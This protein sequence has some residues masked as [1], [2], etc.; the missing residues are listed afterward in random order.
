MKI[1]KQHT[2]FMGLLEALAILFASFSGANAGTLYR[3]HDPEGRLIVTDDAA[4]IAKETPRHLEEIPIRTLS[5]SKKVSQPQGLGFESLEPPVLSSESLPPNEAELPVK[6]RQ[7]RLLIPVELSHGTTGPIQSDFL[8]DTGATIT[9][10]AHQTASYL[11]ILENEGQKTRIYVGG[12]GTIQA[13]RYV[14]D[15]LRIGPYEWKHVLVHVLNEGLSEGQ[16]D[17]QQG[18]LGMNIL[19]DISYRLDVSRGWLSLHKK[20]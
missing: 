1:S 7:G 19:Q 15:A 6:V 9:V 10:L 18:I 8:L 5:P 12:G 20:E 4:R 11:G 13:K 16:Q 17:D 14:L 2:V 3:Y